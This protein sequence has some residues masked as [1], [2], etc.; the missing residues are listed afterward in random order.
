MLL[1]SNI[2]IYAAQPEH[3]DLQD[4]IAAHYPAVSAVSVVEVLGY[5]RLSEPER[6]HFEEFFRASRILAVSDFV[7]SE[8]VKL[9]K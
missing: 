5:D 1:D 6:T 7:I 4:F 8:A 9:R 3:E 2:I